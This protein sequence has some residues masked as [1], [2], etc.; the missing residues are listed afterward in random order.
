MTPSAP[1][2]KCGLDPGPTAFCRHCGRRLPGLSPTAERWRN[3]AVVCWVA[4][5]TL[6]LMSGVLAFCGS[7][8][9]ARPADE[10]AWPSSLAC[11]IALVVAALA[12]HLMAWWMDRRGGQQ[13]RFGRRRKK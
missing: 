7:F 1:C 6:V 12:C 3:V 4:A 5:W 2:Q 13:V 9:H 11:G 8:P 10:S